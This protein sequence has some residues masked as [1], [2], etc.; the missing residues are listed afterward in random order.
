M[1]QWSQVIP[2]AS[3]VDQAL[4]STQVGFNA[5]S[6]L[7]DNYTPYYLYFKD[8]DS[9]ISP[10]W[11]GAVRN[12]IHTTDWAYCQVVSPFGA[13]GTPVGVNQ[14]IHLVWTDADVGASP[15]LSI[16]G[17]SPVVPSVY[18]EET[19]FSLLLKTTVLDVPIS[20]AAAIVIPT[21]ALT[22]RRALMLQSS[23][24]NDQLIY[25]GGS[26]VTADETS[27]GG[28]QVSPGQ[29]FPIDTA[30]AMPYVISAAGRLSGGNQK[31]IV[32]EAS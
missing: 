29:S 32:I 8:A 3:V 22:N 18:V 21:T 25:V 19:P 23:T 4:F 5:K 16:T 13:Q 31:I 28:A 27:T 12:L 11:I 20:P 6:V 1:A 15:G 9:Y 26:G 2:G 30:I 7:I 14:F 10:Y 24:L 17:S